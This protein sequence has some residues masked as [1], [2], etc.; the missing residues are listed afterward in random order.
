MRGFVVIHAAVN[1]KK[2]KEKNRRRRRK[3]VGV[4]MLFLTNFKT[5]VNSLFS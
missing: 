4:G 1:K 3:N 2:R 5:K